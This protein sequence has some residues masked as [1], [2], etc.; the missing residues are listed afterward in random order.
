M[1]RVINAAYTIGSQSAR[2]EPALC[3]QPCGAGRIPV[4]PAQGHKAGEQTE[5]RLEFKVASISLL[6]PYRPEG[7][8]L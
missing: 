6:F 7:T 3:E 8:W 2:L 1:E 4:L 5:L